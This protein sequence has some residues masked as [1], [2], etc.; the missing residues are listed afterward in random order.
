[1]IDKGSKFYINAK[2]MLDEYVAAG[3][4][5]DDLGVKDKIYSYIKNSKLKD[6]NG[7]AIEIE[8]I[9]ELLGHTRTRAKSKDVRQQ[10]INE[11]DQ[12]K[13]SGGSFHIIRKQLPFYPRLHTY[14]KKLQR[15]GLDL[16]YEQIMKG[17]GYKNYS[18]TYFRC[19]GIFELRKYRDENGFV[20][21]YREN[22]KLKAYITSLA[23][24][25]GIPYYL[26]ITLLADEDLYKCFIPT[27]YI[28]Q[29]KSELRQFCIK[30]NG[31]LKGLGHNK[32]LYNKFC[33]LI[34]YCGDGAGNVLTKEDWLIIL[35]LDC[36][37]NGFRKSNRE[38]ININP[39]MEDLRKKVGDN[40][41][42]AKDI[43]SK[44]YHRIVVKSA[45]LGIPINELF[46]SC[47]LNYRGNASNRLSTMQV[48]EIPYLDEMRKLRDKLLEVQGFNKQNGYCEEEIFEA[49]VEAC[50]YAYGKFK[51]KMFNFT[52]DESQDMENG[53]KLGF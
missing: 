31:S 40:V 41:I 43:N 2:K 16:S 42:T 50:K 32:K 52:I 39:I 46:R 7:N 45:Q 20:D 18:D 38:P 14:A 4:N 28:S 17:L 48:N 30:N 13:Q 27:E 37:E 29:V 19:M 15:E 44:D 25:L 11:I 49:K 24:S 33:N 35:D 53:E 10:L 34:N 21:S 5:V 36:F 51:D 9:F 1:M 22:G 3:G 26:I 47:G 23:E 12:Y 8:T 6:T